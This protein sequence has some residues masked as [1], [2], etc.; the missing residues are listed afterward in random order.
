MKKDDAR[1]PQE[2]F[3]AECVAPDLKGFPYP[4]PSKKSDYTCFAQGNDG[5]IWYG[6]KSGVTRYDKNAQRQRDIIMYFSANRHLAD[7]NVEKILADGDNLW[8]LTGDEVTLIEM[9]VVSAEEK[10]EILRDETKK[11]VQRRGMVSQRDLR[12][13]RDF[14][15][16]YPYASC[17]NDGLFT[18]GFAIGEMYRYAVL[19]EKL[20]END[21]KVIEA[22]QSATNAC[23]AC[24][25]LMYI[26][27]RPEG[28]I[29]RSYHVTGE[30]VPDD[31]H[32]Y[33]RKGDTAVC[34]ETTASKRSGR[35]GEVYPANYPVPDRLAKLYRDLGL[36]ENDIVYKAD[37]SSDEISGHF[38]QMRVA[39]DILGPD[40]PELDEI[41]KDACRRT[42]KHI[43]DGRYE[44][45]ECSGKPTT[46]AKWSQ[47]YFTTDPLGYCD[48]CLNAC[49]LLMYLKVT[50]HVTGE[51]GLWKEHYEKLI[52]DGYAEL[53]T[54]RY[55]RAS[56]AAVREGMTIEEDLMYGDNMLALLSFWQLCTLEK[57]E[58]L[59][60]TYRKGFSLW[61]NTLL[62]EHNP[63]Y[64]F[65]YKLAIPD[66]EIDIEK[67]ADWLNNFELSR[68]LGSVR[69]AER[70]DAPVKETRCGNPR[71]GEIS[72]LLPLSEIEISKYDRNPFSATYFYPKQNGT[73]IESCYVYTYGYWMGRY[74]GFISEEE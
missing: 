20:G 10:A 48:A 12:I 64:D 65:M 19:K 33:V 24:L 32:F 61:K 58:K 18:S 39:H 14:E 71:E 23:E 21:P 40:D 66:A 46:W 44:F 38:A 51:E 41:I 37:T 56:Q 4:L 15:S 36:T 54:K 27:G 72:C 70:H 43:I 29:A 47:R 60:K 25:L 67:D 53:G 8:V 63:G 57:D 2:L 62:R 35:A 9:P 16:R 30:P 22:R 34:Y 50:M 49:E 28:F 13:P 55:A 68:L 3:T 17:D 52:A 1:V 26:H 5:V 73:C 31:G 11:Y 59:L 6:G 69:V 74:Y 7:N 45:L 42:S